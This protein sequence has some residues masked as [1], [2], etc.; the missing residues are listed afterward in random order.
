[1][2]SWLALSSPHCHLHHYTHHVLSGWLSLPYCHLHHYTHHVYLTG[3]LFPAYCHLQNYTHHVYLAGFLFPALASTSWYIHHV[4]L[5]VASTSL[6]TPCLSGW[7]SPPHT[8]IY[9]I[10]H[11]MFI[12]LCHLHH[13]THA[14]MH[15]C[16][17]NG[18]AAQQQVQVQ[19]GTRGRST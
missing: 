13:G 17:L 5:A 10:I 14:C 3:S 6:H 8:V 18:G 1:M 11:T 16:V 19:T 12:W 15:V 2:F 9:I 4:Y 7:L